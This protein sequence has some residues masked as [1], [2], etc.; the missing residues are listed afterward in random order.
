MSITLLISI[1]SIQCGLY[2]VHHFLYLWSTFNYFFQALER[3]FSERKHLHLDHPLQ[4]S[5]IKS[6]GCPVK[7]SIQLWRSISNIFF[8]RKSSK[9]HKFNTL[10]LVFAIFWKPKIHQ[11]QKHRWNCNYNQ[12]LHV[13]ALQENQ[14]F[15]SPCLTLPNIYCLRLCEASSFH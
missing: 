3:F 1:I 9:I 6:T 14:N 8:Q 5:T 12:C 10:K 11:V 15:M 4:G 7:K 13:Y 2:E